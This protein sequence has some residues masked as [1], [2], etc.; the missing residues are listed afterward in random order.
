MNQR[1]F[2]PLIVLSIF[3]V[4]VLV[5]AYYLGIQKGNFIS[6][7]QESKNHSLS[8][9]Q[10]WTETPIPSATFTSNE[11]ANWK[12]YEAKILV[13]QSDLQKAGL[14]SMPTMSIKYPSD[15]SIETM[16][17]GIGYARFTEEGKQYS[18]RFNFGGMGF[19]ESG[20]T[21]I[22]EVKQLGEYTLS[23][24]TV[25]KNGKTFLLAVEI[26]K[27]SLF[28]NIVFDVPQTNQDHYLEIYSQMLESFKLIN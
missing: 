21:N 9:V 11:T 27:G 23:Q 14:T 5:G 4:L 25:K 6:T 15:W 10:E 12:Y 19:Q 22:D 20:I 16:S 18:V 28:T 3:L 13:S 26:G 24:R 8:T 7:N 2:S 17:D 1:G